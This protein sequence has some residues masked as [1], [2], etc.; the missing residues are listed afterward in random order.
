[1]LTI[2]PTAFE[3]AKEQ[4]SGTA[5]IGAVPEEI[6]KEAT[7][8]NISSKVQWLRDELKQS[9]RPGTSFKMEY[10]SVEKVA[11]QL[12]YN[13]VDLSSARIVVSGG[14]GMKSGENFKL[15]EDLADQLGAAGLFPCVRSL[16]VCPFIVVKSMLTR[17][18]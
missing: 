18:Y 3:K 10:L 11:N 16:P 7:A 4:S 6:L 9:T 12:C 14:R 8:K 17:K 15:L 2:R 5:P 1:V 13:D